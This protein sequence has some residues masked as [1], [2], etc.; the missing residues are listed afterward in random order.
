MRKQTRRKAAVRRPEGFP[1]GDTLLAFAK[2]RERLARLPDDLR[3]AL[4][5]VVVDGLSYEEAAQR[6]DIP[7]S[8]LLN[9]LAAAR[10]SLASMITEDERGLAS[11]AE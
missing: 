3:I 11:A 10:E 9:R 1:V 6:L 5:L 4:S 7:M 8:A 2:T